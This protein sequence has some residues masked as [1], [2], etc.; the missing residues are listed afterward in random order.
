MK[1]GIK[2]VDG[3][4]EVGLL[5]WALND[6]LVNADFKHTGVFGKGNPG[7]VFELILNDNCFKFS[8]RDEDLTDCDKRIN[9]VW[10]SPSDN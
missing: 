8:K 4:E 5:L 1:I 7:K 6:A 2:Y 3:L 10:S 9:I